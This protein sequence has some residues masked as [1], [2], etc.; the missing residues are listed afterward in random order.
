MKEE[1]VFQ[2]KQITGCELVT[3]GW[4]TRPPRL[5]TPRSPAPCALARGKGPSS[6]SLGSTNYS[7]WLLGL[8]NL[9]AGSAFSCLTYSS[10]LRFSPLSE[11]SCPS[12]GLLL[13]HP[14][15]SAFL[16]FSRHSSLA[17]DEAGGSDSR[18][19]AVGSTFPC[20]VGMAATKPE[21]ALHPVFQS[22]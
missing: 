17:P 14:A 16:G 3:G 19:V 13:P 7:W 22:P 1:L 4:E 9:L 12:E 6:T 18:T 15:A 2:L 10:L 20:G 21:S 5:V 11:T 8:R